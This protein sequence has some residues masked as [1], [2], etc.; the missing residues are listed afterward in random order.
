M[1]SKKMGATS[2]RNRLRWILAAGLGATA[3]PACTTLTAPDE[4]KSLE[5]AT[6][7]LAIAIRDA[8]TEQ[9]SALLDFKREENRLDISRGGKVA[10]ND[11]CVS[12]LEK[13]NGEFEDVLTLPHNS[14]DNDKLF[15][16]IRLVEPC[17]IG[18]LELALPTLPDPE[19][20]V[21]EIDTIGSIGQSSLS[22]AARQLEAYTASLADIATGESSGEVDAAQAELVAAGKGLLSTAKIGAPGDAILDLVAQA[23]SSIVAA[24][25]NK[26]TR[27]FLNKYDR[28]VPI[29]MERL[30]TGA[31]FAILQ[32]ALNRARAAK[33]LSEYANS[34]LNAKGMVTMRGRNRIAVQA[35]MDQYDDITARLDNHNAAFLAL[36]KADPMVAARAFAES[37][38]ALRHIYNDPK[39][40]RAALA[41]GLAKFAESAAAL[42]EALDA[43]DD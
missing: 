28:A 4:A 15:R 41:E 19:P 18:N 17:G 14:V 26:A 9:T 30:G 43:A 36:R 31:R 1:K 35:R 38:R 27:D 20:I 25:R 6:A 34:S 37:H 29:M 13:I 39:A 3:L 24:K 11:K 21:F 42:K 12:E 10:F 5:K 7:N 8:D 33:S 32:A 16:K 2:V 40:N 22:K 23:I